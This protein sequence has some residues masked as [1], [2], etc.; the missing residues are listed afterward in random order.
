MKGICNPEETIEDFQ[1]RYVMS[2]FMS[3]VTLTLL[4]SW[5]S[6]PNEKITSKAALEVGILRRMSLLKTNS[7]LVPARCSSMRSGCQNLNRGG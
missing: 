1:D 4:G 2:I 5:I 3:R 6:A 7:F